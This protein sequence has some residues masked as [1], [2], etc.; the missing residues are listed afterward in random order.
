MSTIYEAL[1]KAEKELVA[2]LEALK[3]K[4]AM[5]QFALGIY[6]AD[7]DNNEKSLT[8]L[9][10]ALAKNDKTKQLDE[11]TWRH[12]INSL[13]VAYGKAGDYENSLKTLNIGI[14]RYPEHGLFYYNLA[15]TYAETS[16]KENA[17]KNLTTALKYKASLYVNED[18][19]IL[20]PLTDSSFKSL[21]KDV[22]FLKIAS[23]FK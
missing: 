18:G 2:K 19:S 23:Q 13:G 10:G 1:E 7:H 20:K 16:D 8:Y 17:L 4:N 14:A 3:D 9:K 12:L 5:V 6:Y 22:G 11:D 15:C 21:V